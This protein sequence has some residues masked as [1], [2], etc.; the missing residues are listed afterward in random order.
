M[1]AEARVCP[2]TLA[3]RSSTTVFGSVPDV[4]F[5]VGSTANRAVAIS[6][7]TARIWRV[8]DF[9][10]RFL[11]D[12]TTAAKSQV[13]SHS[14]VFTTLSNTDPFTKISSITLIIRCFKGVAAGGPSHLFLGRDASHS[15]IPFFFWCASDR[16]WYPLG[17]QEDHC[18]FS[19]VTLGGK[20]WK[21]P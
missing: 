20:V 7:V 2:L 13:R 21:P 15:T 6:D 16:A 3:S 14:C 8:L 5:S 10:C 11:Y 1:C 9:W 18:G 19:P 4:I 17:I 12:R